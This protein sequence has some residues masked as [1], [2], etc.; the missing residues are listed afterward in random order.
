MSV[1]L[2]FQLLI[3]GLQAGGMYA[4]VASGLTLT[5][6]VMKIFNFAQVV[7]TCSVHLSATVCVFPWVFLI[8]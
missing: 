1:S 8:F 7:F 2:F 3:N 6:G 4:L 5:L